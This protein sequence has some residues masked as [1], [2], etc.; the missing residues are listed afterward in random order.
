ME[1]ENPFTQTEL[2]S[3]LGE[4]ATSLSQLREQEQARVEDLL[5]QLDA[6]RRNTRRIDKALQALLPEAAQ[7]IKVRKTPDARVNSEN[8]E[9][10][11]NCIAEH[12]HSGISK[13]QISER[14]GLSTDTVRRGLNDLR[15]D[16]K[17]RKAGVDGHTHIFKLMPQEVSHGEQ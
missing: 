10:I 9:K 12:D 5:R 13:P 2:D 8:Y 11:L 15:A 4:Y 7:P 3:R 16:E 14:T 1:N 17:I 6:A